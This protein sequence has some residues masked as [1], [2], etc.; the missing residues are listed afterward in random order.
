V[1]GVVFV[2][3]MLEGGRATALPADRLDEP[4]RPAR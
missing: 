3:G 1:I 4:G 2:V